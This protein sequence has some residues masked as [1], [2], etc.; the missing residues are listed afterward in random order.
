[1]MKMT[2]WIIAKTEKSAVRPFVRV[3]FKNAIEGLILSITKKVRSIKP[4]IKRRWGNI[5]LRK[6]RNVFTVSP[7]FFG[8]RG[9]GEIN[10]VADVS[11]G[12]F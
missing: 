7:L 9:G 10:D 12:A 11:A 5:F 3:L 1:M 4:K 8:V 2:E 6:E